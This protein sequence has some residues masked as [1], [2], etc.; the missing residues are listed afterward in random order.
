MK[1]KIFKV[2]KI[3]QFLLK[4]NAISIGNTGQIINKELMITQKGKIWI[5]GMAIFDVE[6]HKK[7]ALR[8]HN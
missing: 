1:G 5:N 3:L 2:N 6:T 4:K 7:A 8:F